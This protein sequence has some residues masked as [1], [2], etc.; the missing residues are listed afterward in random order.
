MVRVATQPVDV[1]YVIVTEPVF[2][3]V[4]IPELFTVANAVF[5]DVQGLVNAGVPDPVKFMV[6]PIQTKLFPVILHVCVNATKLKE[7]A[8]KKV[9]NSLIDFSILIKVEPNV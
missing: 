5:E 2:T 4:T 8:R 9:S 7:K 1:V 6:E 3:P